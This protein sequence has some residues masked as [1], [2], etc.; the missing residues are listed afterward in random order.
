LE[1]HWE[2]EFGILLRQR[3]RHVVSSPMPVS[4]G[5]DGSDEDR[6]NGH[7]EASKSGDEGQDS[8][9]MDLFH[10]QDTLEVRLPWDTA[11]DEEDV[12]VEVGTDL[13]F[14]EISEPKVAEG[15]VSIGVVFAIISKNISQVRRNLVVEVSQSMLRIK[16]EGNG[17]DH[18]MGL[19]F[20][21]AKV[22][23]DCLG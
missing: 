23:E 22:S 17:N 11:A 2:D 3:Q 4:G 21:T 7:E 6:R 1:G 13:V 19:P 12:N 16:S 5:S 18:R 10:R 20:P 15:V 9:V 8:G 14:L